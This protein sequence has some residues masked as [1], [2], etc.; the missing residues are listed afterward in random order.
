M[1]IWCGPDPDSL[2]PD[3]DPVFRIP[4]GLACFA[5]PDLY[6]V[7]D[8]DF[9]N[10]L[11]LYY[12]FS[13]SVRTFGTVQTRTHWVR[14]L[15]LYSGFQFGTGSGLVYL[16]DSSRFPDPNLLFRFLFGFD[17]TLFLH[18]AFYGVLFSGTGMRSRFLENRFV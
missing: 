5:D 13:G 17:S 15:T 12:V 1:D 8:S 6:F 16:A 10:K 2:V 18:C 3:L 7:F 4:I 11:F 14:T 9:D